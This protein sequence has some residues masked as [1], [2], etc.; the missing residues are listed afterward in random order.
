MTTATRVAPAVLD[1]EARLALVDAAMTVRLEQAALALDINTAH[2]PAAD[3]IPHIA[4]SPPLPLTPAPAPS[5]YSTPIADLL[6]RARTRIQTDGW[7]RDALY[8]GDGAICPIR[9]IRLEAHGAR[10]LADDA[11]VLL[12][13]RIQADFPGAETIPSW[14]ATQASSQPVI[15]AFDR[16]AHHAHTRGL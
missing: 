3:P 7:C 1:L 10:S 13:D 12:L 8:D 4:E 6:H 16:A 9:A 15:Q 11:C 14:N 5:P 2:L